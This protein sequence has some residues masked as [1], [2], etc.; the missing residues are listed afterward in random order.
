M[1]TSLPFGERSK[2][3]ELL[4]LLLTK[5]DPVSLKIKQDKL[6]K[7]WKKEKTD[8]ASVSDNGSLTQLI[9][10][11]EFEHSTPF[12]RPIW[13]PA[14]LLQYQTRWSGLVQSDGPGWQIEASKQNQKE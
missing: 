6:H 12:Y 4:L 5:S 11:S 3:L 14:E 1:V 7:S 10:L 8:A 9:F 2:G 13:H